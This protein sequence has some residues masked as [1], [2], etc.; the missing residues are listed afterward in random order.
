[1]TAVIYVVTYVCLVA[2]IVAVA[3]RVIG[4]LRAPLHLRWELYP[5]AHDVDRAHYG[6]SRLEELDWWEN[7]AKWSLIGELK[8]MLPEMLFIK[9]L[10][11]N[12]RPLWYRSFPFHFG[13]YILAGFIGLLLVGAVAQLAGVAVGP[14]TGPALGSVIHILTILAGAVGLVL[15]IVGCLGL[16]HRRLT[17]EDL[18]DFTSGAAI[19]NLVFILAVLVIAAVAWLT[20]DRSFAMLRDY[21]QNTITFKMAP[22]G[23]GMV[24]LELVLTSLLIAYIPLTHMSHFFMKYFT[25]HHIRWDDRAASE[26][27]GIQ[28]QAEKAL[29]FPISWSADHIKGDGRKTWKDVATEDMQ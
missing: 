15:A 4:Y 21:V 22:V 28:R 12:N 13:L 26:D 1:M 18:E 16:L 5:I 25:Y 24:A 3:T 29:D 6:G 10:W 23:N 2:F 17:D 20:A 7:P 14:E 19:F 8:G 11:E 27:I 9:A